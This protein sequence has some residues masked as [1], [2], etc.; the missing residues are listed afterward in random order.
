MRSSIRSG[1]ALAAAAVLV[2]ASL[3][4]LT[5]A[6]TAY[7]GPRRPAA[8]ARAAALTVAP[9]TGAS[10]ITD[11]GATGWSV[12][13]SANTSATGAQISTP[14]FS[15]STW[16]PVANDDA[17]APGTE[18]EALAQNGK[19][20]GDTALQP[21]NQS[22]GGPN[23]VYFSSNIELCYGSM[24]KIG[25]VTTSQ[26]DVPWWWRTDFTPNLAAGQT[27]T[28]VVNGAIGSANV[29]VNGTEVATSSTVTGA[30]TKFT[31]NIS[32]LVVSGTN[33]LAI[34][35]NP[36][37]PT[38]M[39]TVDN[40]DWT[41]IPPD[42]NT[43]IQFPV[44]LQVDGTLGV[45]N[46]HVNQNDTANLSS[47]ALT[48]KTDVTNYT[49]TAQTATVTAT[50]TPPG[51]GTP[52]T[53]SQNASVPAS[54]TQTVSFTPS[55]FPS[56]TITSP[57][58][59]WPYQ[60]GTQPLYTLG[61]SVAQGTTQYNS[62][63]ETFGI[64]TV[65]SSL[66]GSNSIE[67][68]GARAFKINGVPIVIRGGGWSPNLFLHYSAADTAKQ[69]AIMKSMGLNAIRLEG[70]IMPADWFQQMD[71]AGILVNGGFQCC[72]AWEVGGTLTQAQLNILQ[73]SAQTIGTNLRNHPSVFSFQWSDN[74]P[75]SQ[76]ES[77]SETG[78]QAADFWPQTPLIA[79]A[80]YKSTTTLGVSGEKEGPYDWVPPNYW[81]DTTHLGSDS[82]VTNA[83][84]AWGYDSEE[85]AGDTISTFDSLN[86]F[87]S[88][89]DLSNL[90]QSSKA[91]QY[92]ANYETRCTT[93][94]SFGT[95]CHFDAALDARYGTPTSLAQ[96][97]EE[98][99]AQNYEGVRAQYEAYIDHANNTPL[100]STGTIYWQMNKGWPSLLWF[101]WNFD[102]DQ[103]GSYFGGQEANRPLH[104]LYA[105]DNGKVTLDNLTNTTQSGLSVESK[106][107]NLSG[108]VTDDQTASNI[109]L[110]S[111]Q[112]M[113][114]VL[115][116]KVPTTP[117]GTTYFVE[118]QLRQ[119]GTLIDR[120]AYWLSTTKDATNWN[121]SLGKPVG[122][123]S[124]Y[125]NLTGLRS[126]ATIPSS[127]IAVTASTATQSGP[128]S[129]DRATTVT[130]TNN[131]SSVAFLLR[132]DVR[133]GTGTTPA[134]GDNELQSSIWQN[135]DIT[136]FPGESQS[137]VVT[138]N[139]SDLN[140]L[141]PVISVSGWNTATQNVAG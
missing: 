77:V 35:I 127:S 118:L 14:G 43:G 33:S 53:V 56:L 75:S 24:S 119:N 138:W 8:P 23:S 139:S 74:Q 69:I 65:T 110:T 3:A 19:C 80:E 107:Y 106:V 108:T 113:T 133:R 129:A 98:A 32:S 71:A 16:L 5:T 27:A 103:A 136:L 6:I 122:V 30:Y 11:L 140:G 125:A 131:S 51:G 115:T 70:H 49:T 83:G 34:E 78:F 25:P 82:T 111:Q 130:I 38:S 37:D 104:A 42:N 100:P 135:N 141:A 40:V 9:S 18:V 123:I 52:I 92:H 87:M 117:A 89:S 124:T 72:D 95:L 67:P 86:R 94:Y 73:N 39:F 13:S 4:S 81:Y 62:T 54:T 55:S 79:S 50:I 22:T 2:M 114:S 46:S 66:V 41:Q 44:Q 7:A 99:Q 102:G 76:Q 10:D 57:Q 1:P 132:A 20:P 58:V 109:S 15:T 45:G 137:I 93:G 47:A 64:R 21:V 48:V 17:G 60:L 112:V 116:P 128:N 12:L 90:W 91:N 101:L 88:A 31:F 96:Y 84:A 28:L 85:S 126:L 63:S 134:A 29:W 121:K 36:N 59:W 120:N 105:L 61:V 26:F 68:S 97:V